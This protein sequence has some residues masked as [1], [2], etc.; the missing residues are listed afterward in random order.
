MLEYIDTHAH[1]TDDAFDGVKFDEDFFKS[2]GFKVSKCITV[3]YNLDSLRKVIDLANAY[4]NIYGEIGIHPDDADDFC[5]EVVS[6]IK[7]ASKSGKIV[8]I[9]EI[10]L[11]YYRKEGNLEE[12][13][14]KQ[15]DVFVK[16]LKLAYEVGLPVVIHT[17]GAI[18]D[19]LDILKSNKDLLKYGCVV[20]CFSESLEIYKELEKMG[21]AISVGGVLTF[22]NAKTLLDVVRYADLSNIML[23]TDC[24]YLT[25]EPYR[26][27]AKNSPIFARF[28]AMKIAELKGIE[29]KDVC[30]VTT[31]NALRIFKKLN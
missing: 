27:Q 6:I 29:P 1:L 25:P 28:V 9:G 7:E 26:G 13:K 5:D 31:E 14:A 3:A 30:K 16:Q 2:E 19:T 23:E 18:K 20:H 8:A 11:D 12:I 24:P 21:I 22:K 4:D 15:K 17:R 10:G